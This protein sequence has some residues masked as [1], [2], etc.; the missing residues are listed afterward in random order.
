MEAIRAT[1]WYR[2]ALASKGHTVVDVSQGPVTYV[3]RNSTVSNRLILTAAFSQLKQYRYDQVELAC[4]YFQPHSAQQ[5]AVTQNGMGVMMPVD[6]DGNVLF[7]GSGEAPPSQEVRAPGS[8]A[9]STT[10]GKTFT[11]LDPR[12][13][14]GLP[15]GDAATVL[16]LSG[17]PARCGWCWGWRC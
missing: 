7:D 13:A 11:A 3:A 5:I 8:P 17:L 9:L 6:E 15:A 4:L 14:N 12:G 10:A 1:G 16:L 2:R